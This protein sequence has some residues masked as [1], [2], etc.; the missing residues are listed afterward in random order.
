MERLAYELN[1]DPTEFRMRN[2]L[3]KGDRLVKSY[4]LTLAE[5]C[6]LPKMIHDLKQSSNFLERKK[7][8][9]EFNKVCIFLIL[10]N[11]LYIL[12]I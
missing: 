11:M 4:G 10:Q 8:L 12:H 9:D 7:S 6:P 5:D 3:K 2:I 1:V